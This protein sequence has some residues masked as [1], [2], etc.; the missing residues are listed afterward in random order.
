M[1]S[2]QVIAFQCF[3]TS[4]GH[5]ICTVQL[6]LPFPTA[7][8][9]PQISVSSLVLSDASSMPLEILAQR[10]YTIDVSCQTTGVEVTACS[11]HV[12]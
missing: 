4:Q 6:L 7:N 1:D 10:A 8:M 12:S 9:K 2:T 5:F 3:H 11:V